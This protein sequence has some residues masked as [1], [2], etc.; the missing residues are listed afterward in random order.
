[1]WIG[2]VTLFPE[3][4]EAITRHGVTG[5]AVRNGLLDVQCWNPREFTRD[6]HRTVDDRPYGGGPG[7]LMKVQP[8]RDAIQAAKQ[9]AGEQVRVIY[10]SPQGRRLDHAGVKELAAAERL[11]LVAGRYEGIDERLVE[12]EIDEE[13]SLGDFVLSGGELPAMVLIDAVSRLVPGVLGHQDSAAED[14]FS[15]GLLD[16]PHYTRPEKLDDMSVPDV[17]LSG[18]HEAIRRWRLKQQLGRT[19]KRRPELL[20]DLEL[21]KEQLTLLTEFIR[22]TE[23]SQG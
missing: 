20:E 5:K 6:K 23:A 18:N 10:L 9:S 2:V 21:T 11:I 14:S 13:W 16:C 3:M 17:L 1:M 7:M 15:D 12:T 19:W 4:F 22:E 8:L